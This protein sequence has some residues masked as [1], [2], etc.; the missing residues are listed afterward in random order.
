VSERRIPIAGQIAEVRRELAL[1]TRVYPGLIAR[2]KMREAEAE[3][4][5]RRM[6]AVLATLMW[7]QANE[8]AIREIMAARKAEGG[9]IVSPDPRQISIFDVLQAGQAEATPSG[10]FAAIS[11]ARGE[12]GPA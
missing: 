12:R 10:R 4:C 2:G 8:A 9:G 6:E 7:C 11:P 3:L 1:R 5:T